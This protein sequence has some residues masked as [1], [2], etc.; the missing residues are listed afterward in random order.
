MS[1]K[2]AGKREKR[3]PCKFKSGAIYNGHWIGANRDGFGVMR[4]IGKSKF[5]AFIFL[6]NN[7]AELFLFHF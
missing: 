1:F 6:K 7:L 5:F 2:N 4:W 3:P